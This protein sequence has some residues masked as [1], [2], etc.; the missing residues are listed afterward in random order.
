VGL[1]VYGRRLWWGEAPERPESFSKET[2]AYRHPMGQACK[3]RRAVVQRWATAP[4]ASEIAISFGRG[5]P[6]TSA[7][8][9]GLSGAS[10][11]QCCY[12]DTQSERPDRLSGHDCSHG[13]SF[14]MPAFKGC[15]ARARQRLFFLV[16]PFPIRI[17]QRNIGICPDA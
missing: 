7:T 1:R 9:S 16:R 2:D 14:E 3:T 11:H 5:M 13:S 8:C 15:V 6:N 10:P 4:R 17:D 12:A